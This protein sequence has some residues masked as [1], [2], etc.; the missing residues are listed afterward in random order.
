[1]RMPF[2]TSAEIT[3]GIL[4]AKQLSPAMLALI[5]QGAGLV[6]V[7]FFSWLLL[8]HTT[9]TLTVMA[10]VIA[11]GCLAMLMSSLCGMAVWWRIIQFVFPIALWL[12]LGLHLPAYYYLAGF[13]FTLSL[14]WTTFRTQVPFYPS[15]PHVWQQVEAIL[16]TGLAINLIDI[17]S[18]LGGLVMH[19]AKARP[20]SNFCGI[21][22]APLPWLVSVVSAW[23]QRSA[24]VFLRG[25]YRG[26]DFSQYDVVFA[27]LS[28]AAMPALWLKARK[29]MRPGSL[30]LSYEFD[31]P[32]ESPGFT[33]PI[34]EGEPSIFGW[35]F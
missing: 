3:G 19:M 28:P 15:R 24:A 13:L 5:I 6:L 22:V 21:E 7:T 1:M 27:Y 14:Y 25:D 35:R 2:S 23:I 30:L 20:E 33:I 17:G 4:D 16:P 32:G 11:Q 12:M 29:E 18:G 34:A 10:V 26:L 31:I 9:L 8:A